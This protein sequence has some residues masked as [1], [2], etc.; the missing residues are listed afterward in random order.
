MVQPWAAIAV[1][2]AASILRRCDFPAAT[3]Q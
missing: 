2:V 1:G 3:Q